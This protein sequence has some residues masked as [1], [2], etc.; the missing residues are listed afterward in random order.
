MILISRI[1][2][3][4][5]IS[6]PLFASERE[7]SFDW[8]ITPGAKR[9]EV[10]VA[11]PS[12]KVVKKI[13]FKINQFSFKMP[14]G[15]YQLRARS[16][17]SREVAG[18]W[19]DWE[20]I[21]VPPSQVSFEKPKSNRWT[22]STKTLLAEF[23]LKWQGSG[24]M[25]LYK[26]AVLDSENKIVQEV[27]SPKPQVKI[28]LPIGQYKVQVTSVKDGLESPD[29]SEFPV[30]VIGAKMAKVELND[31]VYSSDEVKMSW[32]AGIEGAYYSGVL[33]RKDIDSGSSDEWEEVTSFDNY[34]E[35]QMSLPVDAQPG[36]YRV[37]VTAKAKSWRDSDVAV[38]EFIVK[39]KG[40]DLASINEQ[41]KI[42]FDFSKI[43][44]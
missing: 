26:I 40:R 33:E 34:N 18:P 28:E 25:D 38:R 9:Y 4:L 11:Q 20:P 24:K 29:K 14:A 30:E 27:E 16:I 17:D 22:V 12:G 42:E 15:R 32:S 21:D 3:A 7:I 6:L 10:E 41:T 31:P 39:P 44:K 36:F 13:K 1:L 5:S 35:T 8:E 19:S 2:F 37:T 43:S 23:D